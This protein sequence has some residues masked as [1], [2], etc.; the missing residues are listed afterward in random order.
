MLT[1][2]AHAP[3]GPNPLSIK[4]KA[5]KKP[6]APAA[7]ADSSQ[8]KAGQPAAAAPGQGPAGEQGQ[9]GAEAAAG[10]KIRK[11]KR[12]GAKPGKTESGAAAEV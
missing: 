10:G 1:Y 6:G 2:P 3:Q 12:G 4:K 5:T 11:R 8:K 7:K 9:G